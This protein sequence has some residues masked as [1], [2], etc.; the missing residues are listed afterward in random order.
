[1]AQVNFTASA[2]Q[3]IVETTGG[4][5]S[6]SRTYNSPSI[7]LVA[8][9]I[10]LYEGGQYV[11]KYSFAEIGTIDGDTPTDIEEANDLIIALISANFSGGGGSP[12]NLEQ[13]LTVGG[14]P[15]KNVDTLD[16]DYTFVSEDLGKFLLFFGGETIEAT[17]PNGLFD[18]ADGVELQGC[19]DVSGVTI[20]SQGGTDSVSIETTSNNSNIRFNAN[21]IEQDVW[22]FGLSS[23]VAAKKQVSLNVHQV[24]ADELT[25]DDAVGIGNATHTS[26]RN[27]DGDFT[28][29]FDL[30]VFSGAQDQYF[31]TLDLKLNIIYKSAL[32]GIYAFYYWLEDDYTLRV[33]T[34]EYPVISAIDFVLEEPQNITINF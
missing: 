3:L 27:S 5:D 23:R 16:G 8:D 32:T 7:S 29:T 9:Y 25:V 6:R 11:S 19:V 20:I 22:S 14:R 30:P 10:K 4:E 28:V 31:N 34:S 26:V 33:I 13:V 1:M 18:V 2:N 12:Q 15:I 24:D 17:I 21:Q